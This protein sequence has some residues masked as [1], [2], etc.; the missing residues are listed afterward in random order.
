MQSV[1]HVLSK[2]TK[3]LSKKS[4][5]LSRNV[6][7]IFSCKASELGRARM[8]RWAPRHWREQWSE[9]ASLNTKSQVRQAATYGVWY[10]L[11]VSHK[12]SGP[13]CSIR[14][15]KKGCPGE[16]RINHNM[17]RRLVRWVK[18]V[19]GIAGVLDLRVPQVELSWDIFSFTY[20]CFLLQTAIPILLAS[21]SST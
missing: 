9:P 17:W 18:I 3:R 15:F 19:I 16:V 8:G 12:Q 2:L 10:H 5:S 7:I 4:S 1:C 6:V 21:S 20:S 13:G 14:C 11:Y